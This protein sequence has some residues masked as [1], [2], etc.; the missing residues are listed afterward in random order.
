M[1]FMVI[2]RF[3]DR[4]PAPIYSRL[5]EHGRAL[6]EGLRTSEA[7]WRQISIVVSS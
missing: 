1:L 4:D 6:P 5:R 3:R 7:G 2:E